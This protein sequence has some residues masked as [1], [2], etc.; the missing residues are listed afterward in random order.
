[1]IL[2]APDPHSAQLPEL[3]AWHAAREDAIADALLR[4]PNSDSP[5]VQRNVAEHRRRARVWCERAS[6]G[7]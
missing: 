4:K 7:K 5:I 3:L 1:M 2:H 6:R